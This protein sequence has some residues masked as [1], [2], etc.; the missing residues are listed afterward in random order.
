MKKNFWPRHLSIAFPFYVATLSV[1]IQWCIQKNWLLK[2]A[3]VSVIAL[4]LCSSLRLRYSP[5]YAKEDYRWA[6]AMALQA[7]RHGHIVWWVANKL[8]ANYYGLEI[9]QAT[10]GEGEAFAPRVSGWSDVRMS[11]VIDQPL[12]DDIFV[13]R[14]DVH[15][16]GRISQVV[17]QKIGYHLHG[18]HPSFEWWTR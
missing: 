1:V 18:T 16:S 7:S 8:A 10:P 9:V 14:L 6:T 5:V 3:S 17:I 11:D 12:P 2:A 13:S 15:D 4:L